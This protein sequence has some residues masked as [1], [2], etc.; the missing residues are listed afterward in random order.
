[1]RPSHGKYGGDGKVGQPSVWTY[2][3]LHNANFPC[4]TNGCDFL[5]VSHTLL[6]VAIDALLRRP[7]NKA[8]RPCLGFERGGGW[9]GLLDTYPRLAEICVGALHWGTFLSWKETANFGVNVDQLLQVRGQWGV[10]VA[11][12]DWHSPQV[13]L[14]GKHQWYKSG[15]SAPEQ[16]SSPGNVPNTQYTICC[17]YITTWFADDTTTERRDSLVD[18]E[19]T[20]SLFS[21][22]TCQRNGQNAFKQSA[23][24]R[25]GLGEYQ[26]HYILR[27]E[28]GWVVSSSGSGGEIR[29]YTKAFMPKK[30]T[31][32]D[33]SCNLWTPWRG[34]GGQL[35]Q[36]TLEN[37]IPWRQNAVCVMTSSNPSLA[38]CT[39]VNYTSTMSYD[40][41]PFYWL[42]PVNLPFTL[43]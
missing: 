24:H 39:S 32:E 26:S 19:V 12:Q 38:L 37:K 15:P 30:I 6:D 23:P 13:L 33:D 11:C 16:S 22:Q 42:L 25:E 9:M 10:T 40:M 18:G 27:E 35:D 5:R 3:C 8:S 21:T 2:C 20:W 31:A 36:E 41:F 1:M 29:S 7:C 28:G 17:V 43:H 34:N 4:P 14:Q